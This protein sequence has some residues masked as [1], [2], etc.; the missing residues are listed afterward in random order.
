MAKDLI[1]RNQVRAELIPGIDEK[2][3]SNLQKI[4]ATQEGDKKSKKKEKT[5]KGKKGGKKKGGGKKEK[6]LPGTKLSEVKDMKVQQM[7]SC[8]VQNGLVYNYDNRHKI[9]NF[10]GPFEATGNASTLNAP[11]AWELR[12]AVRD[13]C[14]LPMG[15][16]RIKSSIQDESL[17]SILL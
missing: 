8:L 12:M 17:R 4:K 10:V 1:V 5:T 14:I 16:K 11:N 2:L 9:R 7:L 15:T 3:L 6:P 13:L